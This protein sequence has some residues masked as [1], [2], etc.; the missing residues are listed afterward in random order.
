MRSGDNSF[1][2]FP[3]NKLTKLANFVQFIRMLMSCL[4]DW[5]WLRH[6]CVCSRMAG[7]Q[8]WYVTN[9]K[10]NSAFYSFGVFNWILAS[11]WG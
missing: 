11:G 8:S 1:N 6:W 2:Y 5:A 10:V 3:A 7:K 9:P 4:E